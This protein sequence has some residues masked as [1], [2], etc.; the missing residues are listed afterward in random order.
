MAKSFILRNLSNGA[1]LAQ[2]V[3]RA[4]DP[5]SRGVGLLARAAVAADEGLWIDRCAAVHTLGMRAVLDLYFLDRG[6]SVL[7]IE[8]AVPPHRLSVSCRGAK[9]V[10]ELGAR[11]GERAVRVGDRLVLE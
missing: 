11:S 5:L 9:N 10:V 7:R 4:S 3:K 2:R 6:G 1:V 8:R